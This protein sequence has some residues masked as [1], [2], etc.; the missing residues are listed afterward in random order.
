MTQ[1]SDSAAAALLGRID[2]HEFAVVA[3]R[4]RTIVAVDPVEVVVANGAEALTA[5][6]ELT[7]GWWAGYVAYDLGRAIERVPTRA[8]P[9]ALPDLVLARFEARVVLDAEAT[10]AI[11]ESEVIGTG[12]AARRLR[13]A[14]Q[15]TSAV[16]PSDFSEPELGPWE[17]DLD[18]DGYSDRVAT[19]IGHLEAGDCYQV[20]LT[21]RLHTPRRTDPIALFA[22]LTRRNPAPHSATLRLGDV[23][24]VS[25]S[26]EG[27]LRWHDRAVETRPIKGTAPATAAASL[28]A[29]AKDRAENVMIVDLARNDLGRVCEPGSIT[30]PALCVPEIH[31]GLA[32][33][34]STIVGRLRVDV[35]PGQLLVATFPPASVTGAPK[36]RVLKIIEELE[37]A[38]RGVYCG[39]IGW[40][41]TERGAGDLAVAIRTFT[42]TGDGTTFGVGAGIVADSDPIGEWEETELK[43]HRLIAAA[44]SAPS[45]LTATAS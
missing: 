13:E 25:A 39:A 19:I 2:P 1:R 17:S 38:R 29:S 43:A 21:R 26:P 4:H 37:T 5:L 14:L 28:A 27:F 7:P 12:S 16:S 15:A 3:D 22:A 34:V 18:R 9:S 23:E 33:L 36:P 6:D 40:I 31:P 45:L 42:A 24:I 10:R 20:N 8:A 44:G 32:H 41:D 11:Q 35:G 30:V